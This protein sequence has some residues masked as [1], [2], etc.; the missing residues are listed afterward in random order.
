MQ[1]RKLVLAE[2]STTL[3]IQGTVLHSKEHDGPHLLWLTLPRISY[4]DCSCINILEPCMDAENE[5]SHSV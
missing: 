4:R 5:Q 2:I 3:A 1:P